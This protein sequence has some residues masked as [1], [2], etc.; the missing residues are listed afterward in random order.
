M[1]EIPLPQITV[2]PTAV[3]LIGDVPAF[4]GPA[5]IAKP[6]SY[7]ALAELL[8][9]FMEH[10]PF[11]RRAPDRDSRPADL[12]ETRLASE[13]ESTRVIE[14][15]TGFWYQAAG[16]AWLEVPRDVVPPGWA[17]AAPAF[18]VT[19]SSGPSRDNK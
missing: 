5:V 1:R 15:G 19:A 8:R 13:S 9:S 14:L 11:G 4:G 2:V 17:P 18:A 3:K 16:K 10:S 6:T 7:L 12:P